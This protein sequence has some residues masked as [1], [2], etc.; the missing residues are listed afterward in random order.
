MIEWKVFAK[1]SAYP[2]LCLTASE[3]MFDSKFLKSSITLTGKSYYL[4][5]GKSYYLLLRGSYICMCLFV[6]IPPEFRTTEFRMTVFRIT[7]FRMPHS[8]FRVKPPEFRTAVF[9]ITEWY[10]SAIPTGGNT[11]RREYP[12][13][14]IPTT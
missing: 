9:R 13:A 2:I 5:T 6:G 1:V 10:T 3:K 4:L 11:H 14:G 12:L 8:E 7:D